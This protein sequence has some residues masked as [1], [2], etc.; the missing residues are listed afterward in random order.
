MPNI[1]LSLAAL[2]FEA[3]GVAWLIFFPAD[4]AMPVYFGLHF[5]ACMVAAVA[6][7][8]FVERHYPG[9]HR[10]YFLFFLALSFFVPVLGVTGVFSVL[11]AIRVRPRKR[12]P[13]P[14]RAVA[15]PRYAGVQ[16][17]TAAAF[18]RSRV[19]PI[20][21]SMD[22]PID[23]KLQALI[24][25]Q[26]V[27]TR[28]AN[29][30]IRGQLGSSTDDVR[31]LAYGLLDAREKVVEAKIHEMKTALTAA[32]TPA[33][34]AHLQRELGRLYWQLVDGGIAQGGLMRH[35][36]SQ[37]E[38]NLRESLSIDP[39]HGASWMLLARACLLDGRPADARAAIDKA[40]A[41]GVPRR[42]ALPLL[43]ELSFR[44]RDFAATRACM[45]ELAGMPGQQALAPVIAYWTRA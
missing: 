11:V 10:Q 22:V 7:S 29:E 20:L 36:L 27:S 18:S 43:G 13:D 25:L 24:A 34:R 9:A 3:G 15:T 12:G 19:R 44:A 30:L 35:A 28:E 16:V 8:T 42:L 4:H 32:D 33:E 21:R 1:L 31:L 45:A 5:V 23:L 41:H 2:A 37:T 6:I 26:G 38:S 39:D 14:F 40:M 17:E